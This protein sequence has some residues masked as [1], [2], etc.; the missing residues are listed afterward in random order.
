M[1]DLAPLFTTDPR[2]TA[3]T[4]KFARFYGSADGLCYYASAALRW[5]FP[6]LAVYYGRVVFTSGEVMYHWWCVAP[7]GSIV[8]A[9]FA[10]FEEFGPVEEFWIDESWG[11][12]VNPPYALDPVTV[13]MV[14]L[15]EREV[16]PDWEWIHRT[17]NLA[18]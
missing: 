17:A 7:D 16:E 13:S 8:D 14:D 4:E 12:D 2:Y 15:V 6:E 3:W 1:I 5:S 9:T 18:A 11:E 10:Q